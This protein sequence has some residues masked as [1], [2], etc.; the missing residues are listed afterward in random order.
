M[1]NVFIFEAKL[2]AV[3]PLLHLTSKTKLGPTIC[4]NILLFSNSKFIYRISW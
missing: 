3:S 2:E 1:K 4:K